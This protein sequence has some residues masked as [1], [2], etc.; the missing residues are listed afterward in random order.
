VEFRTGTGRLDIRIV[1]ALTGKGIGAAGF[2]VGNE[3]QWTFEDHRDALDGRRSRMVTD[4]Q[5]AAVHE[6]L[7][8]GRYQV[9]ARAHGCLPTI[10]EFVNI[11]G[12]ETEPVTLALRPAAL[13][14]FDLSET[15]RNRVKTDGVRIECRVTNLDT[16]ELVPSLIGTRIADEHGVFLSP[17]ESVT[18][19]GAFLHLPDGRYRIDYEVRPYNTVRRVL[20]LS[21]HEGTVNVELVTGQT[22]TIMLDD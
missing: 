12:A 11:T 19:V 16:N 15:L 22:Q 8:P 21:I 13:A 7:P 10:S 20:A 5:G 9:S 6:D 2:S 3:R 4:A 17:E 18:S 1:D 14:T